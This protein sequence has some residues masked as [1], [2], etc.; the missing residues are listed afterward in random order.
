MRNKWTHSGLK[1]QQCKENPSTFQSSKYLQLGTHPEDAL[2]PLPLHR[3]FYIDLR[4]SLRLERVPNKLNFAPLGIPLSW[5]FPPLGVPLWEFHSPGSSLPLG[6]PLPWEFPSPGNSRSWEFPS[7]G[8]P[9]PCSPGSF[10]SLPPGNST[11]AG[12]TP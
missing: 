7:L 2:Q 1:K 8:A 5:E 4:K 12:S 11:F 10:T 9:L 6:V 3:N